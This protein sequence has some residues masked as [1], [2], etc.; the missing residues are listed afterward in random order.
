MYSA[1]DNRFLLRIKSKSQRLSAS[2]STTTCFSRSCQTSFIQGKSEGLG[3]KWT[4]ASKLIRINQSIQ[5]HIRTQHKPATTITKQNLVLTK[6]YF[7]D[8][9]LEL[10]NNQLYPQRAHKRSNHGLCQFQGNDR[11]SNR[12]QS[13]SGGPYRDLCSQ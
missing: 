4:V 10:D 3:P 6:D 11:C 8:L 13:G 12:S 9:L 2:Q 5:S 7:F 1:V